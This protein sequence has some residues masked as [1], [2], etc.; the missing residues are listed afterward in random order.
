MN[1]IMRFIQAAVH[2]FAITFSDISPNKTQLATNLSSAFLTPY[3][4]IKKRKF[5]AFRLVQ[6]KNKAR[7]VERNT[8]KGEGEMPERKKAERNRWMQM[9]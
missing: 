7:L 8:G 9:Q 6:K 2:E 4:A 5:I 3:V 1:A